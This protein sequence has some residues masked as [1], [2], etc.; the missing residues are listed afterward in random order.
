MSG[1]AVTQMDVLPTIAELVGQQMPSDSRRRDGAS[2]VP[3]FDDAS[4]DEH[5]DHYQRTPTFL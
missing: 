1:T 4:L 5:Q 2:L 3:V